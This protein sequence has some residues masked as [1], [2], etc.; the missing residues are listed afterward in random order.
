MTT[1]SWL[2]WAAL[3]GIAA[4][5]SLWHYH[6]RETPGR[7]RSLLALL[8]AAAIALLLLLLFEPQLPAR[9]MPS[10]RTT[11]V[12]LDASLSM[13]L[14][15]DGTTRWARGVER[16]R[17]R[18]GG[19]PVLLFGAAVRPVAAGALPDSVPGDAR[20]RLL[21]GLQ[22]VAEAGIRRVVIVTDG[23][24]ED[25]DE[26]ARWAPRLGLEIE[27]EMIG[28]DLDNRSLIE[29]SGPVW[30]EAGEPARF[31]F[32]VAGALGDSVTVVARREGRVIGRSTV[33][34]AA[35]GRIATGSLELRLDAPPGGAWIAVDL[36]IEG[37]DAVPDDDRRT[38]FVQ[39]G[40]EPTGIALVSL[41]PDWEPRFLAPVLEQ[42][43]GLPLRGWLRGATGQYV[44]LAGGLQAGVPASEDEVRRAV[45]RAE[46]VVLHGF[47]ADA[48]QWAVDAAENA[49]RV[50]IFPADASGEAVSLPADVG[51]E[52]TGDFF[53]A[54][55]VPTSPVAALLTDLELAGVA[56]LTALRPVAMP[57]GAWAPLLVTRGRQGTAMPLAIGG[58]TGSRY[59]V[60]A[61]GNG[62]WQWAFRGGT[63]RQL[64]T[65]LWG[66]LGGWLARERG[67]T[68]LAVVR[69]ALMSLPRGLPV[70]WVATGVS[71]DSIA[72]V[73]T[74]RAGRIVMDTVVERVRGDTVYSAAPPPGDYEYRATAFAG[75][76][77]LQADGIFTVER[78]SPELVRPRSD[79][80]GLA[81]LAVPVRG[82]ESERRGGTPLHATPYPFVLLVL[83]LAGEWVLRRRW[84]LR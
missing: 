73:V 45:A 84:G 31:E 65:R 80:T 70:P 48:P 35:A 61:L 34:P 46:I 21:P 19:Q 16:A 11:Q 49:A 24:I 12:L 26:V 75:D 79:L 5:I 56:P 82:A 14:P 39:V 51:A 63:E 59:W 33:A 32:G 81:G 4:A 67:T 22:A 40:E 7:G 57:A 13:G 8:R 53:P 18:A 29:A 28:S 1:H 78:Y 69:P 38:L 15:D 68:S 66:A 76:S 37:A 83:L 30:A 44:R 20:S 23:S 2:V 64:Y 27:T 36:A 47:G 71:A 3:S 58:R 42:A 74:A 25:A 62:Y 55:T 41:R 9:G 50:M 43:V 72:I 6:R 60:V 10:L 77:V 52:Q 54:P 17:A